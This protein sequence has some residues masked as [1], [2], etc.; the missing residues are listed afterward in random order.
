MF[1]KKKKPVAPAPPPA[2]PP[3]VSSPPMP[4]V[5]WE[6]SLITSQVNRLA[7]ALETREIETP[8]VQAR[9]ADHFRDVQL[10]PVLP[11]QFDAFVRGLDPEGWR[12]LTLAVAVCDHPDIRTA[13]K[14]LAGHI[15]VH[16]QVEEGFVVLARNT[17]ALT[18][19]LIRQSDVRAEEFA[20]HF[21]AHLGVGWRGETMQQS[22][23]RR[24][25]IDYKRLLAEAAEAKRLAED[26]VEYL[27]KKQEEDAARRRPRGKQ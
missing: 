18:V 27:R 1:F 13:L 4:V 23:N 19:S 2:A 15:P 21:A 20:R 26:R 22:N 8:L 12:R 16:R 24:Y 17:D 7:P 5:E 6:L 25:Q 9:L 3:T 11:R 10:D 14:L